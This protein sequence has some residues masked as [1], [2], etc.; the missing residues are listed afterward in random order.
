[1][2]RRMVQIMAKRALTLEDFWSLKLVSEPQTAPDGSSVAYVV[3]SYDEKQ[4]TLRS[5]INDMNTLATIYFGT[6]AQG[7]TA[8]DFRTFAKL[9][10]GM[11][12]I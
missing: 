2:S 6:A 7:V 9:L 11:G 4:N 12:V 1:M 3:G 8:Y 10:Y 5:A